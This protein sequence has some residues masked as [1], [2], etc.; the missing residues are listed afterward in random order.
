MHKKIASSYGGARQVGKST[1]V[2]S[3]YPNAKIYDLLK[4]KAVGITV[5]LSIPQSLYITEAIS[6]DSVLIYRAIDSIIA[7]NTI[8]EGANVIYKTS[9]AIYLRDEFHVKNGAIFRA[10]IEPCSY[11]TY[12][13]SQRVKSK[14]NTTFTSPKNSQTQI[15][16]KID[17][18]P[19]PCHDV[20]MI[21]NIPNNILTYQIFDIHGKLMKVGHINQTEIT[22]ETTYLPSGV[23]VISLCTKHESIYLKF[24]KQ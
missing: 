23:Y 20:L 15:E 19:N 9:E 2:K 4:W 7:T 1:L 21:S 16:S 12:T 13:T 18:Y 17:I 6:T 11:E 14:K 3:V 22:L 10:M 5:D 8:Q 24:I